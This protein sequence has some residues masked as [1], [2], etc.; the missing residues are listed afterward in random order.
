MLGFFRCSSAGFSNSHIY[1]TA[2]GFPTGYSTAFGAILQILSASLR[3]DSVSSSK[4]K[5]ITAHR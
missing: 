2:I 5:Q 3:Q 4:R 1:L